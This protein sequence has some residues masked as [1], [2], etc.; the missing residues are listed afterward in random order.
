MHSYFVVQRWYSVEARR[1]LWSTRDPC[2]GTRT[3]PQPPRSLPR[4]S[5][6]SS[7]KQLQRGVRRDGASLSCVQKQE[8]KFGAEYYRGLVSSPLEQRYSRDA[9]ENSDADMLLRNVK[10]GGYTAAFLAVLVALFLYSNGFFG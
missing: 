10:L 8:Q 5:S 6:S 1:A 7:A 2:T 4:S 9:P 3:P